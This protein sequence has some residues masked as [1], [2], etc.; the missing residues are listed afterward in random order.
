M[1]SSTFHIRKGWATR[2]FV[3]AFNFWGFLNNF[4]EYTT[5]FTEKFSGLTIYAPYLV[6]NVFALRLSITRS[7]FTVP[8]PNRKNTI[9]NFAR[10]N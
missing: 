4:T 3:S 7:N 9:T 8:R 5:T 10:S 6:F 2:K 1:H